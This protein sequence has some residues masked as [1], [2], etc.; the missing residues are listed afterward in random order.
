MKKC[1]SYKAVDIGTKIIVIITAL[2]VILPLVY[3]RENYIF[4]IH[5]YLD[6]WP[7][8][9]EVL[10]RNHLFW[11]VDHKMPI[12]D[13]NISTCYLYF[14]FGIYRLFNYLFGFIGGEIVNKTSGIILGYFS[15]KYFL[16]AIFQ[17]DSMEFS[18]FFRLVSIAYAISPVYP[19]W[20]I[21]FSVLPFIFSEI[22]RYIKSPESIRKRHF[23]LYFLFGFFVYF[24]C[25]G[26]FVMGIWMIGIIMSSIMRKKF[27]D[28]MLMAFMAMTISAIIFNINIFIYV[29]RG[30]NINRALSIYKQYFNSFGDGLLKFFHIVKSV[31]MSGQY[32]AAPCLTFLLPICTIGIAVLLCKA[33]KE[34]NYKTTKEPFFIVLT[35]ICFCI[36][37][38]MQ[39]IGVL[40]MISAKLLP[41]LSGFNLGR[42][43]FFNNI[44][45][46]LLA[47][48]IALKLKKY[49]YTKIIVIPLIIVQILTII[50]S[51]DMY[52][53]TRK[54][55]FHKKSIS[56]GNVS[57]KEFFD[58]EFF[59]ALKDKIGYK[60][61]GIINIGYHPAVT[62]YNGYLTLDGYLNTNPLSYHSAFRKMI[63]P[64]LEKYP[65]LQYYYD[66]NGIRLYVYLDDSQNVEPKRMTGS[67]AKELLID[68]ESFAKLGGKFIFS[69][70]ELSNAED[71]KLE[72]VYHDEEK[73]LQESIYCTLYVY[74]IEGNE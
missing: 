22:Y 12:M 6:E 49:K 56:A 14:D 40:P 25:V 8:L 29:I 44:L 21:S 71:L 35:M 13:G 2:I 65:E 73:C 41:L 23:L 51:D 68:I 24:P 52:Y 59:S 63:E 34:K 62:M 70:Y 66:T 38:G 28:K 39:A 11:T 37:Y 50:L 31:A 16:Y 74:E 45:W 72:L 69:L 27:N 54:N 30:D 58:E 46:Y 43:V 17:K 1:I 47:V 26:I 19:N 15:M 60:G 61:E 3:F 64:T 36:I 33:I 48:S 57:Y 42:I 10:R 32:H 67:E 4:T 20:T 7:S 53:E 55:L 18:C 9:F 5:D